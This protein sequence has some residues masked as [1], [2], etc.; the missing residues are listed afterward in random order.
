MRIVYDASWNLV[1][2][3]VGDDCIDQM[4]LHDYEIAFGLFS[5]RGLLRG[6]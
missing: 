6:E 2:L 3:M 5:A 1:R 4:T